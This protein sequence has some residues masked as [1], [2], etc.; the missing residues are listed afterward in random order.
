LHPDATDEV[1]QTKVRLEEYVR[2]A[3]K[4]RVEVKR[5]RDGIR[6]VEFAVQLLQLVHGRRD[7]RLR[8]P[9]TLRALAV[10]ADEV[11]VASSDADS[12]AE[13]YRFL[14]RVEHRLQMVRDVQTHDIPA[15]PHARTVI[16]R[17]LGYV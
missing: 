11:Y 4:E 9:N 17:S 15:D 3:G 16:A 1:R 6:D 8:E 12:M 10:L 14:R 7:E 13:S 2:A 5:G